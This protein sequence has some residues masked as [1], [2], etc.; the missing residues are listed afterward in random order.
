MSL[1]NRKGGFTLIELLVVIAIIGILSAVVLA[2]LQ[3]ARAKSRDA[4]RV[5]DLGQIQLALELRF[6]ANQKYLNTNA[7]AGTATADGAV[8][9]LVTNQFLPSLP[10][11][12]AGPLGKYQYRG[13]TSATAPAPANS[14]CILAADNCISYMLA[15]VLERSDNTVLTGDAD[16]NLTAL[17]T[18]YAFTAAI[19]VAGGAMTGLGINAAANRGCGWTAAGDVGTVQPGGTELCYDI[20]P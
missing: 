3:T 11:P 1:K 15:S 9:Q 14:E 7:A 19:N 5:S 20:K 4:K 10:I 8:T 18:A 12:P 2:S 16:S 13:L 6:D 17:A